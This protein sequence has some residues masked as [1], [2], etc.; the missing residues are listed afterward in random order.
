MGNRTSCDLPEETVHEIHEETGF[1]RQ[2]INRLHGRFTSLAKT[3]GG[4]LSRDDL[5]AIPE[6]AINP[7]GERIVAAFFP[8]NT[9]PAE[10]DA[11]NFRQFIRTLACFRPVKAKT[12]DENL[13]SRV[14]KLKFA[15]KMYDVNNDGQI[16]REELLS[17]L[18]MMVGSNISQDQLAS[19][20][21]RTILEADS[22]T[23]GVIS[24]DEFTQIMEKVDIEQRMSIRFLN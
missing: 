19:I 16:T 24:F 17:L 7:L 23:D 8:P 21:D 2:Q 12:S 1:S 13:N 10:G 4:L 6:I 18:N 11:I 5:M 22:D 20:A 3:E 15:F 9:E 14:S